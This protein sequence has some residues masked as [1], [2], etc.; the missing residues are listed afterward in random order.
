MSLEN[1]KI[2]LHDPPLVLIGRIL[3]KIGGGIISQEHWGVCDRPS[4]A[5]GILR[6]AQIGKYFGHKKVTICEFGVAHGNGL[7]KMI[8]LAKQIGA[9][10]G[11]EFRIVGFDT[12]IGL[13]SV[14]GYK[15][16]PEIWSAGD[17][18]LVDVPRLKQQI[19]DQ[20]ELIIG[21]IKDT[22]GQFLQTLKSD[23]PLG[24][25]S[26]D[27]DTYSAAGACLKSLNGTP[28]ACLPA[29]SAYFDDIGFY[30]CNRWCGELAAIEDF[31]AA[32]ALRK[33]DTDRTL[34]GRRPVKYA[35]WYPQMYVCHILDHP[36]RQASVK[37]DSL[38]MQ[39]HREF[40]VQHGIL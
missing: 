29:V 39:K 26:V 22:V 25:I 1:Y 35:R 33:I 16:H 13:P 21:D 18:A 15:E 34:P 36:Q 24:F 19:G 2:L 11:M 10:T 27:V 31:N 40:L 28:E 38:N 20:A 37:R 5:Y 6:A 8:D 14:N 32:N 3:S 4:Y 9:A 17:F 7:L 12:G 23:A 30:F